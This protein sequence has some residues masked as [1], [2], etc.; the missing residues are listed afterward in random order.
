MLVTASSHKIKII[1]FQ[2]SPIVL[3]KKDFLTR[4]VDK[5]IG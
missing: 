3:M 1:E 4:A 2:F 5:D